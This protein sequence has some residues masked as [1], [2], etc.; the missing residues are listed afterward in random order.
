MT[1]IQRIFA[2]GYALD[3]LVVG[4]PAS[5]AVEKYGFSICINRDG[6]DLTE[7]SSM[8]I[9]IEC[10][11]ESHDFEQVDGTMTTTEYH[12]EELETTVSILT[13]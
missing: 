1:N 3:C 13:I 12:N 11:L 2:I 10:I 9:A 8:M 4:T 5:F 6:M 7:L